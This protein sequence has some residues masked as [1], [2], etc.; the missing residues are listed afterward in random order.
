MAK[1]MLED[2]LASL[3]LL[4][5]P[6][7]ARLYRHGA[8]ER[9]AVS[10]DSAAETVGITRARAAFHLDKL[11]EGGLLQVEYR[12]LSGRAGRG[13]GRPAK[14]Y[15]RSPHRFAASV[16][17]RNPE[18]LARLLTES[19]AGVDHAPTRVA[20]YRYG[21]RLGIRARRSLRP[22]PGVGT[23]ARCV[24][25]VAGKLGFE[26]LVTADETWARNC[27]FDPL[28]RESPGVVCQAAL[29]ILAGV[30]DGVGAVEVEVTRRERS[31]WC[32]VV[33]TRATAPKTATG[34]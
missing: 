29:A 15:R 17:P 13:A 16:P 33:L 3:A 18:L 2:Q 12:R 34:V 28:S 32:C 24:D 27:P 8:G 10:R 20:S 21:H 7:R 4:L 19:L 26:P 1:P 11:V 14:L 9:E 31:D 5:E 25:D 30:R 23:L 22:H 6:T